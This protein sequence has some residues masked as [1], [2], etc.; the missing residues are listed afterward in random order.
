MPFCR[1]W[2]ANQRSGNCSN[3]V[4]G[5]NGKTFPAI[6]FS[7]ATATVYSYGTE[8]RQRYDG[9]AELHNGTAKRQRQN[10][11]GSTATEGWKPGIT[12]LGD[13][14]TLYASEQLVHFEIIVDVI[15]LC[16]VRV[17]VWLGRLCTPPKFS[18]PVCFTPSAPRALM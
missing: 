7:R 18:T 2:T 12:L 17:D 15:G 3:A 9:T 16:R 13:R 10:D 1:C 8:L 4:N 5:N 6:P 14:G 11:N